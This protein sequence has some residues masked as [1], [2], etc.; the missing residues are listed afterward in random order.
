MNLPDFSVRHPVIISILLVVLLVF[1]TLAFLNLNREMIPPVALPEAS[2]ITTWPGAGVEDV[3]EAITR[4]IENQ[5]ANLG[6]LSL[7]RSTSRSSYSVVNLEFVDGTDV[8]GR[9]PEI[10]ELLNEISSDLPGDIQGEPRILIFEANSLL[11]IYSFQVDTEGD[12]VELARFIDDEIAPRLARIP[13]MA[14]INVIGAAGEEVKVTL[15]PERARAREVAPANVLAML[16]QSNRNVPA[17]QLLYRNRELALTTEGSF[18]NLQDLRRLV[19]GGDGGAFVELG[20]IAT[21]EQIVTEPSIRVRSRGERTVV[22]DVL[23]RDTG[24]TLEIVQA[25]QRVLREI[26]AANP[27]T[28]TWQTVSD[29]REMTDRSIGTVITSALMGTILATVAML[30]FLRDLRATMII[31]VSI[32]LSMLSAAAAMY[33]SGQTINLLTLSGITVAIGMIVDASIVTLENTWT[34]FHRSGDPLEAA[35]RGAGEM[36]PAVIASTLTSVCVFL[37]LVFLDGI[38][39]IIMQDLSLTIVYALA[40]AAVVALVVV[41]FLSRVLLTSRISR[42]RRERPDPFRIVQNWYR[43]SVLAALRNPRYVLVLAVAILVSSVLLLTTL[44]VSFLAPTDTGE[45]E[46]HIETPR[47]FSLDQTVHVVDE[48]E[49]IVQ[50][51]VPEIETAVYY[52]GTTNS[53]AIASVPNRAYGRIRLAPGRDRSR[54][55]QNLIPLLQRALDEAIPRG[56]ITVLNGG[57]DAM[58]ALA[59]AGQ[60]YQLQI[61]G[62]S[63]EQVVDVAEIAREHLAG[64]PNVRKA[65][66]NTVLDQEQL[67]LTLSQEQMGRLGISTAEAGLTVRILTDGVEAGTFLAGDERIPVRL[68]STLADAAADDQTVHRMALTNREGTTISFAA[69]SELEPRRTVSTINK[70]DRSISATV[71]GFLIEEDQSGVASRM[72]AFMSSLD[73]PEGIQWERAGTSRLIVDSMRR[74]GGMLALAVFL[75]YVVMVIQFERYRQPLIIMVA[76]PFALIGV[77]L[78]LQAFRSPLSIIAMLGLITLGGTVVNNA[79]VMVDHINRLRNDSDK[80]IRE[81]VATGATERLRPILM[82]TLT[83]LFAVLPMAFSLGDGAEI[84]APLGQ[85]IFGGLLSSTAITLYVVPALYLLVEGRRGRPAGTS[86]RTGPVAT[87]LLVVLLGAVAPLPFARGQEI[88]DL[89]SETERHHHM[90]AEL[91]QFDRPPQAEPGERVFPETGDNRQVELRSSELRAVEA[92]LV[93]ARAQRLPRLVARA[94]AGWLAN[95]VEGVTLEAGELGTIPTPSQ[96]LLLPDEKV[97][98]FEGSGSTRYEVGL[99]LS[100][101]LYTGGRIRAGIDAATAAQ[102]LARSRLAGTRHGVAVETI[103]TE[104]QI[105]ILGALDEL[106]SL[107]ETAAVRLVRIT[108]QGWIN[109]FITEAEYLDARLAQ[110][111]VRLAR[112]ETAEQRGRAL[113]RLRI[114]LGDPTLERPVG[115]GSPPAAREPV[116]PWPVATESYAAAPRTGTTDAAEPYASAPISEQEELIRL[117]LSGNWELQALRDVQALRAAQ[118]RIARGSSVFRPDLGFQ[119][120]LSWSGSLE[121]DDDWQLTLGLGVTLPLFDGGR[122]AS[123][124]RRV[125]E[126]RSQASTQLLARQE[127][128]SAVVRNG[129]RRLETLQAR[130]EHT[131][132]VLSVRAREVKDAR[133]A[134]AAG[135]GGEEEVLREIIRY[136][137]AILDGYHHLSAYRE[138]LWELARLLGAGSS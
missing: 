11:P 30:L 81:V 56:N 48:V 5:L 58:L 125:V 108:E 123:E 68:V 77:V 78:G 106:F 23:K 10:R 118:E 37:P 119:V 121:Q 65:E 111:E 93:G 113:E 110:Q 112:A 13:G 38:I 41:P 9:L 43:R 53:L 103:A 79:I 32:P 132:V 137:T 73:L 19:V 61:H 25:T 28:F 33:V 109:G 55:I 134:L 102:R 71:R 60:G 133:A 57:L 49:R 116:G 80:D 117:V 96:P 45:F 85:A 17:G 72:E 59:T 130:M 67:F 36:G 3:E 63:L 2:I 94:E 90:L 128:I 97:E 1:G 120:D 62:T 7:M 70:R 129:L 34:H 127:E 27:G 135:A 95:P 69:F 131:T 105:G 51:L 92:E 100:Q 75:V 46:I 87:L 20:D 89:A 47:T 74:L 35:R 107:Q 12:P 31:A 88:D 114:A 54:S 29:Q 26:A 15:D 8:Y 91:L 24:N 122:S 84:Y 98:L 42:P 104:E 124:V 39:G 16:N 83:T 22:V 76:V 86:W 40:A 82:T 21:V 138:Q 115:S 64:D 4:R 99:A 6:G 126:E 66:T 14:R 136:L 50:D 52:V 18:R 44:P 101:P